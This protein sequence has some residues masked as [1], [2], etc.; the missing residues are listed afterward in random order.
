[1]PSHILQPFADGHH[2]VG[3]KATVVDAH[4]IMV[5]NAMLTNGDYHRMHDCVIQL[6]GDCD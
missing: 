3:R 4:G 1:M 5:K 2:F 6:Y